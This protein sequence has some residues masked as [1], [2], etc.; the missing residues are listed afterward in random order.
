MQKILHV[1]LINILLPFGDFCC[2]LIHIEVKI[3]VNVTEI[4]EGKQ[5]NKEGPHYDQVFKKRTQKSTLKT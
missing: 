3:Y 1:S 5:G 4:E 2:Y